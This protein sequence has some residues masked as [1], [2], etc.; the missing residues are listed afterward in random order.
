MPADVQFSTH[1][2]VRSKKQVITSA[3]VQSSTIQRD[4]LS[5]I[6]DL[7]A[8]PLKLLRGPQG[9]RGPQFE[10]HWF[11]TNLLWHNYYF[12][13]AMRCLNLSSSAA[14]EVTAMQNAENVARKVVKM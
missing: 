1:N 14:V 13:C 3:D 7:F 12:H 11:K 2:Q 5:E 6:R 9:E 8:V 10:N 4:D